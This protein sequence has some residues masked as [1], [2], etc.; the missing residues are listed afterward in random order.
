MNLVLTEPLRIST[1]LGTVLKLLPVAM[2]IGL[3]S[4]H[5]Q[6]PSL[7]VRF[8]KRNGQ[9][10]PISPRELDRVQAYMARHATEALSEDGKRAFTDEGNALV[11]CLPQ[12]CGDPTVTADPS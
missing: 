4:Q 3:P 11:E 9:R 10:V 2:A 5:R 12:V 6:D 1:A 8:L 7:F